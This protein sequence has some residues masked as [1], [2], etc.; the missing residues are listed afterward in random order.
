MDTANPNTLPHRYSPFWFRFFEIVPGFCVWT[1]LLLPFLLSFSAP[2]AVTI[3]V[4]LFDVYWL[5]MTLNYAY[6]LI[7]GY[8][9]L[10]K[11]ISCDWYGM[12]NSLSKLTAKE[13]E[14]QSIIAWEEITHAIILTSYQE[15]EVTLAASIQSVV[16]S[17]YDKKRLILVLAI[18]EREGEPALRLSNSL[19]QRFAKQFAHFLTT[20]HPDGIVGEVKA[21]GANA[22]WAAK[23]LQSLAERQKIPLDRI[24][25]STADADTRFDHRYFPALSYAFAVRKDRL[26]CSFQPISTYFNNIW[27]TPA[28]SRVL[29]FGTTFWQLIESVRDYRLISFSTHA[30]SLHTL[31][32]T[33]FWDTTIVNEDSRQYFRAYFHY[34][35][36]FRV[37]P[38][39]IPIYMDAVNVKNYFA[40]L[41][42][43]YLQQQRWAY[44]VEHFP[45]IVLESLRQPSIPRISRFMLIWRAFQ[46]TFSWATSSFFVSIIGWIPILLNE[47][48]REQVIVSNFIF[49]TQQLLSLTWIGLLV[50]SVLTLKILSIL[51]HTKGAKDVSSMLA[52]W[53]LVPVLGIFFGTLPGLDAVTRLMLGKY[54]GFR[55]TKKT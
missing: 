41:K 12:L 2:L 46:G 19:E 47:S 11:H 13:R 18:E 27:D 16:D 50:S 21:K 7:R 29:A 42:N 38:L 51:P 28:M 20:V 43:L 15:D 23:Q 39:Y 34:Q 3:F 22:T 10:Q 1:A 52:Q 30:V 14:Q 53:I 31:V 4:L 26:R 6:L 45:Y 25:V 48:F 9:N 35:G 32:E 24:V 5:G 17:G 33:K 49:V 37:I 44:G 55:V 36:D 40:T 8:R 54:I